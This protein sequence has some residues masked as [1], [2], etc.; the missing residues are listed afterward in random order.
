MII[1]IHAHLFM[2]GWVP[3][4]WFHGIAR[5]ITHE[6]AKQGIDQS[7]EEVGD[8]LLEAGSD[9]NAVALL[10]EYAKENGKF[11]EY[12]CE[13]FKAYWQDQKDIGNIDIL[14]EIV[15]RIG[16]DSKQAQEYL[17][18]ERAKEKRATIE[19]TLD[20]T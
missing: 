8:S 4:K 9:P 14:S 19:V 3:S 13:V 16:L 18:E 20:S 6:F 17:E 2:K 5:F 10:E 12:H 11:Y 1:D 7:N 15:D